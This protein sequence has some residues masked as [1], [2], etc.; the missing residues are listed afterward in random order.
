MGLGNRLAELGVLLG[1]LTRVPVKFFLQGVLRIL[2][3]FIVR[4]IFGLV[5]VNFV[6]VAAQSGLHLFDCVRLY[7]DSQVL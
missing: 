1:L 3:F 6:K 2:V 5:K 4:C 7:L